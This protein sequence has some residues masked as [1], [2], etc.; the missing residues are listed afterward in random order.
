MERE[1]S[2]EHTFHLH[3]QKKVR[4]NN[5]LKQR[6]FWN[7]AT[8]TMLT[9]LASLP[10]DSIQSV[11][12][13]T[14]AATCIRCAM[15]NKS[16]LTAAMAVARKRASHIDTNIHDETD[17]LPWEEGETRPLAVVFKKELSDLLIQLNAKSS[18]WR[19]AA[20]FLWFKLTEK[21]LHHEFEDDKVGMIVHYDMEV[22]EWLHCSI[23]CAQEAYD[24]DC[25]MYLYEIGLKVHK[26]LWQRKYNDHLVFTAN[27]ALHDLWGRNVVSIENVM[28]ALDEGEH[29]LTKEFHEWKPD[30]SEKERF[31]T[32]VR[33][34]VD[35]AVLLSRFSRR[36]W[37]G[38][39]R[40][41]GRGEHIGIWQVSEWLSPVPLREWQRERRSSPFCVV[42]KRDFGQALFDRDEHVLDPHG[43]VGSHVAWHSGVGNEVGCWFRCSLAFFDAI[44]KL[45]IA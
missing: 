40:Y 45:S 38:G 17:S 14:S 6:L 8:Q 1:R 43:G 15:A 39:L 7:T 27:L 2:R 42:T 19:N 32:D 21:D 20:E 31:N 18:D 10:D 9:S 25:D 24:Q 3:T 34:G 22:V 23:D 28:K 33:Q 26:T 44:E 35:A 4:Q 41:D 29:A 36:T 37:L 16:L 11:L 5:L 12:S 13:H 30:N